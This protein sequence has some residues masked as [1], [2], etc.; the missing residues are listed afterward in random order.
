M[1]VE[2]IQNGKFKFCERYKEPLSG[3]QK[4]VSVTMLKNTPQTRKQAQVILQGKIDE[5]MQ[6]TTTT[7]ITFH[8]VATEFW[9]RYI[10]RIRPQTVDTMRA[11]FRFILESIP[12][13]ALIDKITVRMLQEVIDSV[14]GKGKVKLVK[15]LLNQIY[16]EAVQ[17][18]YI[19]DN[20]AKKVKMPRHNKSLED[21]QKIQNKYLTEEELQALLDTLGNLENK[22]VYALA[23]EFMALNGCRAGELFALTTDRVDLENKT[24]LID[25]N[26]YRNRIGPPKT[27]SSIRTVCLTDREIEILQSLKP[28]EDGTL[29]TNSI[30]NPLELSQFNKILKQACEV[31]GIP[32]PVSTHFFRHTLVSRLAERGVPLKAIMDRVGHSNSKTTYDIYTHATEKMKMD[33]VDILNNLPLA[34][35]CVKE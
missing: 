22:K 12:P 28:G 9:E 10:T 4:R 14:E 2:E 25:R 5:K 26:R 33:V 27:A 35:P 7:D 13:D 21:I 11:P 17:F 30:G 15:T 34:S 18:E 16:D 31:T 29:F 20:L 3:K 6:T 19:S 24:I 32:K 8:Q 23:C 1:W